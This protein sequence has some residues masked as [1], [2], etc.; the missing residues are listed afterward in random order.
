M[1]S[2]SIRAVVDSR[3]SFFLVAE[4]YPGVYVRHLFVIHSALDGWL[5]CFHILSLVN[6]AVV[7]TDVQIPL[8]DSDFLPLGDM[9]RSDIAGS[10]ATSVF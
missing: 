4:S 5:D 10:Y 3:V 9:P 6:N 8:Q 2:R 1:P 7:D